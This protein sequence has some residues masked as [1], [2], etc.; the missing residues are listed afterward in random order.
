MTDL[1]LDSPA[2]HA[3]AAA[4]WTRA[5]GDAFALPPRAFA[6][7]LRAPAGVVHAGRFAVTNGERVGFVLASVLQ[8]HPDVAPP[9][10][11]WLDALVVVPEY[12]NRGIGRALFAW[13]EEW[14]HAQ[15]RSHIRL[16]GGI[17]PFAPGVAREWNIN[18]FRASGYAPR[19]ENPFVQDLGRDLLT[20][21]SPSFVR[22]PAQPPRAATAH[23]LDAL[24][25]FF[26]REFPGRWF[27][28]FEQHLRDGARI[29]DYM[30]LET[31]RGIDACCVMTFEDSVRPVERYYPSPLP[32]PWAQVGAI[33]VSADRRNAGYGSALLDAALL[34]LQARGVRG[35]I[36]DWTHH[37]GYYERFGF[38]PHR[39]YA[40]LVKGG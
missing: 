32:R 22:A 6:Y 9:N 35:C 2:D 33:G 4:L 14:L 38:Q 39:K 3:T 10:L 7:N 21:A 31:E 8:N 23:D 30:L 19:D 12:Q 40:M 18:F 13:A 11:G 24:R 16:G 27:Y 34:Y 26:G 29:E 15:G 17:C 36:I 5:N 37:V 25:V 20:Y 1:Q 28:E